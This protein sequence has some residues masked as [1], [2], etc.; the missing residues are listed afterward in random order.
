MYAAWY[1]REKFAT[2]EEHKA[3]VE[4]VDHYNLEHTKAIHDLHTVMIN[5]ASMD[6]N[7]SELRNE[8]V[9]DAIVNLA[10]EVNQLKGMTSERERMR[11]A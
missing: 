3:L 7:A 8:K 2:R 9:R 1:V 6:R 11:I 4:K 5:T 10:A